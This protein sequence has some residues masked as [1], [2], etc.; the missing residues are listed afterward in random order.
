M[1]IEPGTYALGPSNGTLSVRTGRRGAIA[2]AGHDL[3]I[4]VDAWGA[5]VE[6]GA[7]AEQSVLELTADSN[8]LRVVDGSGGIQALGDDD[9]SGIGQTI[10]EEVLQGTPIA[11]RSTSVRAD[12]DDRLT[13]EGDLEL[14]GGINPVAF[15]LTIGDDGQVSG[16]ATVKQT[17]WGMKPYTALFGTLKVADEVQVTIDGRL[18]PT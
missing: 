4:E 5:T 13:V 17:E 7:S 9:R 12:G 6:I 15:E 10:R 1:S 8:S 11:F 16:S 18:S 2:K 3:Q 14:A